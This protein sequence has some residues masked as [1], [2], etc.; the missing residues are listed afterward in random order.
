[1]TLT[2]VL[3][4]LALLAVS[5][6]A[7]NEPAPQAP[8]TVTTT[9]AAPTATSE[10]DAFLNALRAARVP[11]SA[12][13]APERLVGAGVC[14]QLNKGVKP[15]TLARDLTATGYTLAQAEAVVKAAQDH[16]C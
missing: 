15:E 10:P 16:L 14:Q 12:S 2:R 7:G 13:G 5:G 1:M 8:G 11:V 9:P 6:C 3:L 4:V